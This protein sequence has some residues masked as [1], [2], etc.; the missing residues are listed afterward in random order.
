MV[1]LNVVALDSRGQP[2]GDL[3]RDDFRVTDAGKVRPIA[4]FRHRDQSPRPLPQLA[5]N[6]YSNRGPGKLANATLILFD[7]LNEKL[8]TRGYTANQLIQSLQPLESANGVFLYLLT[9][10]GALYPLRGLPGSESESQPEDGQ[11]WTRRIKPLMDQALRAVL[12]VRET[13]IVEDVQYRAEVT[14]RALSAIAAQLASVPGR[15]SIIWLSDGVPLELGPHR[16]DTG[17]FVDYTPLLRQMSETMDRSGVSIYPVRMIMLGSPDNIDGANRDGMSSISTLDTFATLTGGRPGGTKDIGAALRQA[18]SDM[19][20]S[21][22]MGYYLPASD[23]DDK[24]H[25][26]RIECSRKGVRIQ[27]KTGYYAWRHAVGDRSTQ[28]L[29]AAIS[30]RFDAAEIGLRASLSPE[31][32]NQRKLTVHVDANDIVLAH[33]GESYRGRLQFAF[34]VFNGNT[35]QG[36]SEPIP[37]DLHYTAEERDSA[38]SKGIG[39][40]QGLTLAPQTTALR[41]IVYDRNSTAIGSVTIPVDAPGK[42]DPR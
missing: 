22:E 21:Y 5:P 3:G 7:M 38:F 31:T 32:G 34:A 2:V 39:F 8:S 11:P 25:K 4:F 17:D 16:S 18:I 41:V 20:T 29:Q 28:A 13:G 37:L 23:W 33:E 6:E 30:S 1:D 27:A 36:A 42:Q 24:F 35:A 12:Q 19:R 9:V 10:N 40:A 15:K 14:F 26:L